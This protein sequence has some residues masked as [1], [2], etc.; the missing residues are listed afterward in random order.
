MNAQRK[1]EETQERVSDAVQSNLEKVTEFQKREDKK[2]SY[3]Q[4]IIE[5]ASV[6]FGSPRFLLL[7]MTFSLAWIISDL[8]WHFAGHAYFDEPP[9]PILQGGVTYLGVLITMA[10]LVRQ[11][12]LAQVEES[13]AHLELQVNLLA[14]QK[15]TKIIRLL[16]ELRRDLPG[17]HERQDAHAE[18]LQAMTN[19]DDVLAEIENR[20]FVPGV[21]TTR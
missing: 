6:F 4:R 13:R 19:P 10:V 12:R 3:A 7:F 8:L 17:V 16:E 18:T 1:P 20:K 21:D 9:F 5:R 14:E 15:A 11:N 2:R